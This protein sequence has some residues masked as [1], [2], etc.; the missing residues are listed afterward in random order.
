MVSYPEKVAMNRATKFISEIML[1]PESLFLYGTKRNQHEFWA[2]LQAQKTVDIATESN[3]QLDETDTSQIILDNSW[4]ENG[5]TQFPRSQLISE[6]LFGEPND[7]EWQDRKIFILENSSCGYHFEGGGRKSK[8]ILTIDED[9]YIFEMGQMSE[10]P[11]REPASIYLNK[12]ADN[13]H[14]TTKS[15]NSERSKARTKMIH[16]K[17]LEIYDATITNTDEQRPLLMGQPHTENIV[18]LPKDPETL[19]DYSALSETDIYISRLD[20]AQKPVMSSDDMSSMTKTGHFSEV[21]SKRKRNLSESDLKQTSRESRAGSFAVDAST[22]HASDQ[23]AVKSIRRSQIAP[24]KIA[25]YKYRQHLQKLVA[26]TLDES[27]S[28]DD[29][30]A[31]IKELGRLKAESPSMTGRF[32]I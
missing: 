6:I 10:T 11:A 20:F 2:R 21:G 23:M 27:L 19:S 8:P 24:K 13:N 26:G 29:Y 28:V 31:Q 18:I 9:S 30:D 32:F 3:I 1:K 16:A 25:D 7:A 5:E 4:V 17:N 22:P 14:S 15:T 12:D